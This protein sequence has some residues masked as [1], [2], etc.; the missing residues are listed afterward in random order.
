ME[1]K[2]LESVQRR[3]K[4]IHGLLNLSYKDRIQYLKLHSLE[5]QRVRGDLI[6]VFKW[7]KG[8]LIQAM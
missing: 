8:F 6:E 3:M 4:I 5:R 1:I 2:S 7:M